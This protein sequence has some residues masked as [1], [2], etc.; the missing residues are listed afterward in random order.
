MYEDAHVECHAALTSE[1]DQVQQ[2]ELF[3]KRQNSTQTTD[4]GLDPA[5]GATIDG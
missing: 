5:K 4:D 3:A 1:S 2:T